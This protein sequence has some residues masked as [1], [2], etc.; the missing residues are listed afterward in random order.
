MGCKF[1]EDYEW[2]KKEVK[3]F[4]SSAK[5]NT[6]IKVKMVVE[7][8]RN[9]IRISQSICRSHKLNYCPTC[10]KHLRKENQ[11]AN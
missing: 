8:F 9:R 6:Y 5:V 11:N 10:G 7:R 2:H 4:K 3:M 1:C